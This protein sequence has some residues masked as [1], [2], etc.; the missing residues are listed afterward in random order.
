MNGGKITVEEAIAQLK[1]LAAHGHNFYQPQ[2]NDFYE[3]LWINE[4]DNAKTLHVQ[5]RMCP[6]TGHNLS[7]ITEVSENSSTSSRKSNS[8]LVQ[9]VD[10]VF[11]K[12]RG[13]DKSTHQKNE[14]LTYVEI[15]FLSKLSEYPTGSETDEPSKANTN[16]RQ[17]RRQF[18]IIREK[19]ESKMIENSEV[20]QTLALDIDKE[21]RSVSPPFVRSK[22]QGL[23]NENPKL[24]S[25][26]SPK[27]STLSSNSRI[28]SHSMLPR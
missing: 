11:D 24:Q 28:F 2:S 25:L 12:S 17:T 8:S 13:A 6:S 9:T 19:F 21:N 20:Q 1:S 4:S 18:S 3:F 22:S 5:E 27:Q 16:K 14:H 15:S 7:T 23:K 10:T 26:N